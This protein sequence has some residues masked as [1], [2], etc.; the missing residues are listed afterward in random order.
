MRTYFCK[1]KLAFWSYL[2]P[3]FT[4]VHCIGN[5]LQLLFNCKTV[6]E[7]Y[8]KAETFVYTLAGSF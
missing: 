7:G 6:I 5:S 8:M 1:D 2:Y 3:R 4:H